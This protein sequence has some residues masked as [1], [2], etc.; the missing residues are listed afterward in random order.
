MMGENLRRDLQIYALLKS[1]FIFYNVVITAAYFIIVGE[2]A[3]PD[4]LIKVQYLSAVC[5]YAALFGFLVLLVSMVG[6]AVKFRTSGVT[7][8]GGFGTFV[9]FAITTPSTFALAYLAVEDPANDSSLCIDGFKNNYDALYFSY[10]T[11]T[12]L[13]YGDLKPVGFCRF[14]SSLEAVTG[15]LFLGFLTATFYQLMVPMSRSEEKQQSY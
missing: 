2:Y 9:A 11:L 14:L 3:A 15:Y 5:W 7:T 10:T 8:E 1:A 13:G 12:T 4:R 6:L